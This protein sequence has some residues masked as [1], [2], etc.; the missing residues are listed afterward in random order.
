MVKAIVRDE[1]FLQMSSEPATKADGAVGQD[2]QDTLRA[3]AN[4]CVGLAGNMIGVR[5]RV[6]IV[7]LEGTPLN[8]VMYNPII[9]SSSGPYVAYEGCLSLDGTRKTVRYQE[10]EVS[11][12][13]ASWKEQRVKFSGFTA[14][15]IQHEIDHLS[16]ILI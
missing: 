13:D 6:I 11:F 2:L 8:L 10:I 16:G 12:Q 7:N 3:N 1:A 5:K 14:Q 9:V 4:R 15:T